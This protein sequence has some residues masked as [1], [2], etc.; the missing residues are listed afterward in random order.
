[1]G[2]MVSQTSL[3]SGANIPPTLL[4]LPPPT[5]CP[6]TALSI[7][8]RGGRCRCPLLSNQPCQGYKDQTPLEPNSI[9]QTGRLEL[10]L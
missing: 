2:G 5:F 7:P 10:S 6:Q 1:M 8:V 9:E 4:L 3:P